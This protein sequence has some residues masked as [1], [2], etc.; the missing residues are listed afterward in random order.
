[1]KRR[2]CWPPC[3]YCCSES[4]AAGDDLNYPPLA[5]DADKC[6]RISDN[7]RRRRSNYPMDSVDV[8]TMKNKPTD[9]I[10]D[11]DDDIDDADDYCYRNRMTMVRLCRP[12]DD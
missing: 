4:D 7:H 1:M 6:R 5:D 2:Y 11:D 10:Q 9:N 12:F 3:C 8:G